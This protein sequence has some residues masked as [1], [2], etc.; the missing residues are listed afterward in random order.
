MGL[1][2]RRRIRCIS[3]K[4]SAESI[5]DD[6]AA[7]PVVMRR[8]DD[9]FLLAPL[10]EIEFFDGAVELLRLDRG[11]VAVDRNRPAGIFGRSIRFA[12]VLCWAPA[13]VGAVLALILA[14]MLVTGPVMRSD[15]CFRDAEV[16]NSASGS[17]MRACLD[18]QCR[19]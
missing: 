7:G 9:D 5:P 3:D 14:L 12:A 17:Q 6:T 13:V 2:R 10:V 18:W 11:I 4:F 1:E 15:G 19:L 16:L 8:G